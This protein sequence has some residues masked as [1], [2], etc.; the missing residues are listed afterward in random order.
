MKRPKTPGRRHA[1]RFAFF[2]VLLAA[3]GLASPARAQV[4]NLKIVTDANPD[5]SDIGSMI[6]SITSRWDQAKDKC[7]ALWYWTHIARR[8][9]APVI[10]HGMELTDPIRQFNDYGYTMCSTIAGTNCAV[11]GAMGL[12]VKFWDI[13]LHTVPEVH[14]DGKYHMYDNSLSAIYTLCDGRTVAG[15]EDIGAEGAC[16]A[17]GGRLEPGHIARYHCLNSTSPNGFLTGCDTIRSMAEEYR[18]FNPNGL[19]YRYYYNNWDLGH[20]YILNLRDGEVYTRHY[21]RLDAER[22]NR[23]KQGRKAQ[24][25]ADPAYFVPNEGKDPEAANPRYA[26]RGNGIRTWTPPLTPAGLAK[27]AYSMS[28]V[29]AAAPSGVEPAK[30]GQPGQVVFKVEGANVITSLTVRAEFTLKGPGDWAAVSFRSTNGGWKELWRSGKPGEEAVQKTLTGEVNGAYDILVKVELLAHQTP[31]NARL[32]S[33]SFQTVTMLNSKTQPTLRLGKNTVYV[34]AGEQTES[35]VLWPDLEGDAYKPYVVEQKN[36]KTAAKHPGYMGTM[37][38]EKGGEDAYVVFKI[39]APRQI[40]RITYGGRLYNRGRNAHIDFLHSFDGGKTWTTS[41]RLRDTTPPWDVIHYEKVENVPPGT[42]AVLIKYLWN[43]YGA[44]PAECSLY[45]VRMEANYRPADTSFRPLDVTFTWKERQADYSLVTR[46]HTQGVEKIPFTYTI[47]VGGADHPVVDSLRVG[48][49]G[50]GPATNPDAAGKDAPAVKYGYSDGKDPGGEKFQDRWVTYGR[51]LALGKPYTSTVPSRDGWGAGDPDGKVLTDGVVG[52]PYVGGI[53]YRYGA[54]WNQGDH[55]VVTVDLGSV[56]TCGA[57][58]IQ[59]GGYPFWDA[60]KG[61]VKDKTEVL[62]SKDGKDYTSQGLFDFNLRWKDIPANHAW[63]D[64]ETLC[65]PN[66]LLVPPRPV[67]A[68]FV[69]FDMTPA[70]FLSVSEV[71]VLDFVRYEPF[72]LKIALPD[73]KDRSDITQYPLRH[74]PSSPAEPRRK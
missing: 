67:Q 36:V 9:T 33:I 39:E 61:E 51:N 34:G 68:R 49:Q 12:D 27:S 31:S 37:F 4:C 69:R 28:G 6:H 1:A 41:Y 58:R 64:E 44:G 30:P 21:H 2:A 48:L 72:D 73:G 46:S 42:T 56:Q 17:S 40:T 53:A 25:E 26:I 24:Y 63:P 65:G 50:A 45:A 71:Q 11:W 16:E 54:L 59:T 29:K 55:P 14:Y 32:K 23:A 8:Q 70:R 5:Y 15:V 35:I 20:R 57:F 38:A 10:L 60:L 19:K 47:N 62:T 22:P 66:Y 52:S 74:T 18:C 3:S 43:A 7:W 13:S